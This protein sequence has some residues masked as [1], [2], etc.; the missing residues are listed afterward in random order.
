M[1][2]RSKVAIAFAALYI[3][4]GSTYLAILYAIETLPPLLMAGA[5]FITAGALL[6]GFLRAK[7]AARP[8]GPQWKAAFIVGTLLLLGGNGG[9]VWAEQ[10][11]P[12]GIAALL[13]AS[14]PL[15]MV[16]LDA[17]RPGG[18]RPTTGVLIGL[19]LGILGLVLL[20]GPAQL[21]GGG[22]VNPLGAAV[23][24]LASFLWALGSIYS[25]SAPAPSDPFLAS[26]MQMLAGGLALLVGG[27][28]R[29]ELATLDSFEPSTK[30]VLAF[31]YLIVFG[32]LIGFTAYIWLLRV[33]TP[34]KVATYAYVNPVVAVLLG[35]GLAD[36]PLTSRTLLAAAVIVGAVALIT[37]ARSAKGEKRVTGERRVPDDIR[38]VSDPA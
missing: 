10:L 33:S 14:L 37:T 34:A 22:R 11:V 36:E 2:S 30:S 3:V 9:V 35:W 23:L 24:L 1:P 15:W 21:A 13:V 7:G 25:R 19:V 4:W 28:V 26:A 27:A 31:F 18:K 16:T 8:T 12:S 20:I 17:L 6:Y 38:R 29:G 5:R 32:S